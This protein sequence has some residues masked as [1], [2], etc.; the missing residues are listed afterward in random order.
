MCGLSRP[1]EREDGEAGSRIARAVVVALTIALA[2]ATAPSV[3]AQTG[4]IP[5]TPTPAPMPAPTATHINSDISSGGQV[6]N[7]GSNFLE[8]LGNQATNGLNHIWNNNSGGGG[9]SEVTEAPRYRSWGEVYGLSVTEDPQGVFFGDKRRI[10]GGVVGVGARVAPG[11]NVG[12]SVDQSHT[13][14]DVPLALQ[15]ATIDL[16]QLGFTASVDKGPWTWALALV[17]GFGDIGS[18]RDTGLGI[19]RAGYGTRLDGALTELSYYWDLQQQ[20]RIVPKL[21]LE[22]VRATAGSFQEIGGLNPVSATGSTLE[23]ARVM[24][25]TEIG[26]YFI[27]D[28]KILDLSG[29]GKFVDNFSQSFSSVVVSLGP[30][31]ISVQGIGES[32]YGADAGASASLLLTNTARVYLNYDGKFRSQLQSHQGTLGLELKW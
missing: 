19:A 17:H 20:S 25:G 10:L 3:H 26:H 7:L 28:R 29:Y 6:L 30:Q 12:F 15:S 9:A 24:L 27:F 5:P 4:F 11:V 13:Q 1:S 23:R 2:V 8:R 32:R 16:T 21:D 31:A 14:V 22:Y 18:S